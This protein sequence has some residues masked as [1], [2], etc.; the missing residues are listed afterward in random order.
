M[1]TR[2]GPAWPWDPCAALPAGTP[3]HPDPHLPGLTH[4]RGRS[5]APERTGHPFPAPPTETPTRL[6]AGA[7]LS[8][9]GPVQG[10][11]AGT[12]QPGTLSVPS[13]LLALLCRQR[14]MPGPWCGTPVPLLGQPACGACRSERYELPC[15]ATSCLPGEPPQCGGLGNAAASPGGLVVVRSRAPGS[16]Q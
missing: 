1:P 12:W 7:S 8:P 11:C 4:C 15:S 10:L 6:C 14:S 2:S 3:C 13:T 5:S 16:G 9:A